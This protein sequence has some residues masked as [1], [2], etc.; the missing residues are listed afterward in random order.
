MDERRRRFEQLVLPHLDAASNLARWLVRSTPEAEDI[1]QE[2]MLRAFRSF[3]GFRGGD[4]RPW[5]LAIV[6]NCYFTAMRQKK[7]NAPL[8]EDH[9]APEPDPETATVQVDRARKL[10]A[11]I[12]SLPPE[13]REVLVLREMEEMSYREIAAVTAVPIGTV[14]SRLSRARALLRERWLQKEGVP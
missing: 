12:E 4:A 1:V 7:A 8:S 9:V 2:A 5:L 13:F 3:D 6:R 11:A 10:G 14:M